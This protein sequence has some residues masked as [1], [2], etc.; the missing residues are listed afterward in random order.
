M[1]PVSSKRKMNLGAFIYPTGHHIA[2]WRVPTA[3]ADAGVNFEHYANLARTAERGC[4]D[5]LFL[6]DVLAILPRSGETMESVSRVAHFGH[7]EP[8][9]LLSALAA[10]TKHLGLVATVT[11]TYNEPYHVARKFAS[12]DLISGGRAAWNLVTSASPDEAF[13]FSKDAHLRHA[14]RYQRAREFADVVRGLWD[15]WDADA[16][17][18][19]KESGL[20]FDPAKLRILKHSGRHFS[21]HGPLNVPRS[22]QGAPVLVQAGSSDDGKDLAAETAEVVFTAHQKLSDAQAFYADLKERVKR[23][24]RNPDH[25]KI[26]PGVFPVVGRTEDEARG[27]NDEMQNLIHR[28][29]G[30]VILSRMTGVDLSGYDIDAPVPELPEIEGGKSRSKMLS[31]LAANEGLTIRQLYMRISGARGHRQLSGT[32]SQIADQLEE[33]FRNG[34]ADGFN[35]MPP[36]L[37]QGLDDFVDLV[38]PELQRRGLF[39]ER[40]EGNTLRENLGLPFPADGDWFEMRKRNAETL[41]D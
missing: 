5:M 29:V 28:D 17:A 2:A 35:I 1:D 11:T 20:F 9:T 23:K 25:V 33:W 31:A 4:F 41:R 39:R 13:N 36:V 8:I 14:D 40:Y 15:S 30:L 19:D 6:A 16:F 21:V 37:P 32:P 18:R 7:F 34:A 26:M 24:G 3:Q 10:L 27:K 38:I 22:P 12:L